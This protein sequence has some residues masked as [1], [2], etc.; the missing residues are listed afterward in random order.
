MDGWM[1]KGMKGEIYGRKDGRME[2]LVYGRCV[3]GEQECV[4]RRLGWRG[5]YEYCL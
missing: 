3:N 4:E 5:F 2:G 1:G